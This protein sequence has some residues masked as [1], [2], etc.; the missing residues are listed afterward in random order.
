MPLSWNEI[1]HRAVQFSAEWRDTTRE[2]ADAKPFLIA[3]LDIFGISQRRVATFE[4]RVKRIDDS[5]GYID[6]LWPGKLMAVNMITKRKQLRQ[7]AVLRVRQMLR[8]TVGFSGVKLSSTVHTLRHS[9]ATYL[10]KNG[11]D[12]RYIQELL[13]HNNPKTTQIYTQITK[14]GLDKI[15]SPL[16]FL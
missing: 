7:F 6:L 14:R 9:F 2:E 13:G 3:F 16:D 10:L 15:R 4:H 11:T 1:K 12:L 8:N 5:S